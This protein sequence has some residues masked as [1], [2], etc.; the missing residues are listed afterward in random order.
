MPF[1]RLT[2][3][4]AIVSTCLFIGL[5]LTY[6]SLGAVHIPIIDILAMFKS[7]IFGG[8]ELATKEYPLASA[9]VMHIRLPRAC[10]AIMAGGALA[11]AGSCTQG[12]FKNPLASPDVLGVSSGSSFGAV[13]AI[14]T[15]F[16]F[17]NPI[18]LPVFTTVGALAASAFIYV[19]ASRHSSSQILF[20]ILTGL[21]LS[22]LL[23]G[24]RMGLLLM[25]QQYEVSQ[26]VFWAMGGLD[27]R[28][29]QHLLWPTPVIIIVSTLLL[30]ESR[31]LNLLALGEESAHGMGLNVKQTRFKLLMFA[32]LL[33]AMSIAI[34]GPIGFIGLMVPH[35]VRLLVG[36]SHEKLLPFSAIFGVIFL[37][38]CDLLGRWIIAPNELKAGIITSFIG[39]CYFIGLIIRFQ[40]KGRLA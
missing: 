28:M 22:S 2:S 5:F 24:A 29:W 11:L 35:L 6:L 9:I 16:S 32:T 34:A 7:Y 38:V 18:W 14:V 33:T 31:S 8:S 27:G 10:A 30:K 19:L 39:G 40:R 37:L 13:I 17:M 25:A 3:F 21:A 26:F 12:L 1:Y 20:L 36:P 4:Q 15:G 23:G